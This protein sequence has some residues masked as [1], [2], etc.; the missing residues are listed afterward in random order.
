[1]TL[2]TATLKFAD[3]FPLEDYEYL[4]P[5]SS[6]ATD[7][8]YTIDSV[9]TTDYGLRI[10]SG[11]LNDIVKTADVKANLTTNVKTMPGVIYD[12]EV[13]KFK[14][15]EVKLNCLM[16][17]ATLTELWR[18]YDALLYNLTQPNERVLGVGDM[19]E[20][21]RFYYKSCQVTNFY[22]DGKIWLQFAL[23]VIFT[24]DLRIGSEVLLF[25]EDDELITTE[26]GYAV[27][28]QRNVNL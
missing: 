12:D 7:T 10:L 24:T 28:M 9:P 15:K 3:D 11:T 20:S 2:C 6:L 16:T 1:M 23:T 26:T 21:F 5:S 14:S 17:A 4:A 22:P 19:Q 8:A 18:N 25:S 27:N 13:V